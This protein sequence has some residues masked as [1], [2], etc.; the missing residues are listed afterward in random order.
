[1]AIDKS[2]YEKMIK[3]DIYIY[4]LNF[5]S[6]KCKAFISNVKKLDNLVFLMIYIIY[7]NIYRLV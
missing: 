2:L 3:K 7:N 5:Q 4:D 1:M 6:I